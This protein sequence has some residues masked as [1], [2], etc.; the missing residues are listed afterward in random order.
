MFW[1]GVSAEERQGRFIAQKLDRIVR[2]A[3]AFLPSFRRG[4]TPQQQHNTTAGGEY[5]TANSP[6]ARKR[7]IDRVGVTASSAFTSLFGKTQLCEPSFEEVIVLFRQNS[8]P[9]GAS[10]G[11]VPFGNPAAIHVQRFYAVSFDALTSVLPARTQS[12]TWADIILFLL[13]AAWLLTIGVK[14]N[15]ALA[16]ATYLDDI[17]LACLVVLLP[18]LLRG[19]S[20]VLSPHTA[21]RRLEQQ[22]NEHIARSLNCNRSVISYVRDAAVHQQVKEMALALVFL[23]C[24]PQGGLTAAQLRAGMFFLKLTLKK[25]RGKETKRSGKF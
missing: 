20:R 3:T 19:L 21:A 1:R 24:A 13:S 4:R 11:C 22:R 18:V 10:V 23:A 7:W 9:A 17:A 14:F 25:K 15:R 12:H 2:T 8:L 5:L 6:L 16:A